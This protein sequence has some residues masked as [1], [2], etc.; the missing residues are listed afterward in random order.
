L[1]E[2]DADS[3]VAG[4]D[5]T[6]RLVATDTACVKAASLRGAGED[7]AV[8]WRRSRPDEITVTLP[9]K[10]AQPGAVTLLIKQEG[11]AADDAVPLRV[12][13]EPSRLDG[14]ELHSGEPSGVVTGARLAQVAS[15]SFHG[16][17]FTPGP[18][19]TVKGIDSLPM[20]AA[21]QAAASALKAGDGGAAKVTLADGR[22]LTVPVVVQ[23]PR[24]GV[25]LIDGSLR[26]AAPP[27]KGGLDLT[28]A[29]EA[30]AGATLTFAVRAQA[31]LTFKGDETV[32]VATADG[33]SSATL[34]FAKGL[35]LQ[36]AQVVVASLDTGQALGPSAFGPL[37]FRIVSGGVDGGWQ[38]LVTLVR[39]PTVSKVQCPKA[40]EKACELKGSNLF[41]IAALSADRG[42]DHATQV[43]DGFTGGALPTPRPV[44]GRLFVKLRDAP[45]IVNVVQVSAAGAPAPAVAR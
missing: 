44:G 17:T 41:L 38:P 45:A 11:L 21:D 25:A 19:T 12:Y 43:P 20:A 30:P 37:R 1:A 22:S 6:V 35:V 33:V 9:L 2:A 29:A 23:P 24:P 39:L 7:Q 5:V 18:M 3:L 16:L 27:R 28:D 4:H 14:F 26:I 34:T 36:D 15:L 40:A 10:R 8:T 31:P 42:F 32:E 13:V